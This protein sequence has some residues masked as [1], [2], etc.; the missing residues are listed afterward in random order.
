MEGS[1]RGLIEVFFYSAGGMVG[2]TKKLLLR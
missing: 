1:G 2:N